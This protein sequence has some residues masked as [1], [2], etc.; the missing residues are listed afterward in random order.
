M[1]TATPEALE[2]IA[3]LRRKLQMPDG[4]LR[5]GLQG[6][7][8]SGFQYAVEF[9]EDFTDKDRM[10]IIDGEVEE[11]ILIDKR[12]YLFLNGMEI[13][14]VEDIVNGGFR[15]KVPNSRE[16]GCGMSFSPRE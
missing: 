14:Y 16:C 11:T 5:V 2:K 8:C 10:V 12:S 13:D 7:G 6:G 1:I 4:F 3:S 15:F 9:T